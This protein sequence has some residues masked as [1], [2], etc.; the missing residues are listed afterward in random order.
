MFSGSRC[1]LRI[2][3]NHRSL[4]GDI[5]LHRPLFLYPRS[6][7]T[8]RQYSLPE[9]SAHEPCKGTKQSFHYTI[10]KKRRKLEAKVQPFKFHHVPQQPSQNPSEAQPHA[11]RSIQVKLATSPKENLKAIIT[12]R[13][14]RQGIVIYKQRPDGLSHRAYLPAQGST[15]S[16][17]PQGK[18]GRNKRTAFALRSGW[19]RT[20]NML[21]NANP[22]HKEAEGEKIWLSKQTLIELSGTSG[23][24][25]WVHHAR[26]G[27]EVQVSDVQSSTGKSRQV[28]LTGSA[29]AVALTKEYFASLEIGEVLSQEDQLHLECTETPPEPLPKREPG[30]SKAS[31]G[32]SS[33]SPIRTVLT[34]CKSHL[35][36][37]VCKR[38]DDLPLSAMDSVRSFKEYV[39]ELTT[40]RAPRLIRRELYRTSSENHNM[41]V[42]DILCRLFTDTNT[43]R[44]ASTVAL[45]LAFAF[46]CK[47]TELFHQTNLLYSQSRHLRLTLQPR[48]Y[49]YILRA[50]LLQNEITIFGRVL[51][52]L[53]SEGHRPD[54]KIW[55]AMLRSGSSL[56]QKGAIA[57]WMYRKDLLGNSL[58]RGQVA[59]EI[60][61]AELRV[62]AC[63]RVHA[64][65]FITSIDNR[66][67]QDWMSQFSVTQALLA[68]AAN[69]AWT[70]AIEIFKEA[71]KRDVSI[72]HKALHAVLT[73][74]HQ[75]GSLR[76]S[77]DL[78]R[79]HF[80]KT[81]GRNDQV[82]IPIIFMT[83]WK[84]RFYNVC[85]VLW[86]YAAV[87]GAVTYKMQNV[88]TESLLQNQDSPNSRTAKS[89]LTVATLEWRRR[90]GKVLVGTDL[91]KSNFD[92]Y[93]NL[94][95]EQS[96]FGSTNPM[97]WLAQYTSDGAQRDQQSS[98]AY[99]MI[100]RDLEAWKYFASPSSGRLFE[101]LADGYDMDVRWKSE[102]IGLD[103]GGRSTQ[104][105][106]ENAVEV[107]LVR[108]EV[109]LQHKPC[110]HDMPAIDQEDGHAPAPVQD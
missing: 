8:Q 97:T 67:G 95:S 69:K 59:A 36:H 99:V 47:H 29:R 26:G 44:S 11:S 10:S 60:I 76:D 39:E 20:L 45:N 88:V 37:K 84:N 64:D 79:S 16:A 81:T 102:G 55:L 15:T 91:D 108:R 106:I 51:A 12:E 78:L 7:A 27:C 87:Q 52:D 28:F 21:A 40:S 92:R 5:L 71:Q 41:I 35:R 34:A 62:M 6:F 17:E 46:L 32:T 101:L 85:R 56:M 94:V 1:C 23:A 18:S 83:A 65:L 33:S 48:T 3:V 66:F 68:C 53:L 104:W 103:R 54:S 96:G 72:D 93:F 74:M 30:A 70:L 2:R 73:V 89:G 50:M 31:Q 38:A 100:H 24:N 80:L 77:L 19:E 49:S 4:P 25:S 107:P 22:R 61:N 14:A 42:A 58:V 13:R 75:R 57:N 86:R 63:D 109:S 98:L 82:L 105:M 9:T 90:A 110:R 43:A